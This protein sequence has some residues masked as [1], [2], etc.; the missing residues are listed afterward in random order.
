MAS[1]PRRLFASSTEFPPTAWRFF[2]LGLAILGAAGLVA[3]A[4]I[5]RLRNEA[6]L[7]IRSSEVL[8][9]ITG[10]DGELT[11][12]GS[13]RRGFSLSNDSSFV[14]QYKSARD[15]AEDLLDDLT[16]FTETSPPETQER[17]QALTRA[18]A[19]RLDRMAASI[20]DVSRGATDRSELLPT[21]AD[22]RNLRNE[23]NL[24]LANERSLLVGREG[25]AELTELVSEFT[26]SAG[27]AIAMV[28]FFLAWRRSLRA[29]LQRHE[30]DRLLAERALQLDV[31]NR[32]LEQLLFAASERMQAPLHDVQAAASTVAR[33][34]EGFTTERRDAIDRLSHGASRMSR[35]VSDL[36]TYA[37]LV[38]YEAAH[39]RVPLEDVVRRVLREL[40]PRL[41]ATNATVTVQS[42]MPAVIGDPR[43]VEWVLTQLV[44]NAIAFSKPGKAPSVYIGT[45]PADGRV[46]IVVR[47]EGIGILRDYHARIFGLFERLE[48]ETHSGSG[49]GLPIAQR[50][51][52]LLG[53]RV[54]V[55]SEPDQGSEFIFD[56]PVAR[57]TA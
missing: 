39:E 53:S 38:G 51:A 43:L 2:V 21:D 47:D 13:A 56:L 33:N 49:I 45:R 23:L 1:S 22:A 5:R 37:E 36:R 18:A 11:K 55:E 57:D 42:P 16:L 3:F 15:H 44:D 40:A 48:P 14:Y 41:A 10:I 27:F 20:E 28:L 46:Q 54:R 30:S 31:A 24:L 4:A 26:L 9:T 29:A 8:N 52:E 32:Q 17:V 12:A 6:A 19:R 34:A 50:A 25:R 7:V 35:I